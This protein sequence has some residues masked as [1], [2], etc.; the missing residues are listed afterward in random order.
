MSK[1]SLH[2]AVI[3]PPAVIIHGFPWIS[4]SSVQALRLCSVRK[5]GDTGFV[6]WARHESKA[7]AAPATPL[8]MAQPSFCLHVADG[9]LIKIH[10]AT[11]LMLK[12]MAK[13][14]KPRHISIAFLICVFVDGLFL[15]GLHKP[16]LQIIIHGE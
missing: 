15:N 12:E 16:H 5:S 10:T 8:C 11:K 9:S 7:F 13:F 2:Q 3:H 4:A 6:F 14:S 1:T